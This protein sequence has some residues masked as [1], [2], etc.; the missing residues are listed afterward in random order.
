MTPLSR[1]TVRNLLN[2]VAG[3]PEAVRNDPWARSYTLALGVIK[4]FLGEDWI[5][6]HLKPESGAK[7]FLQ[8]DM[9]APEREVDF[10]RTVDLGEL[11]FNLQNVEGFD[12]CAARLKGGDIQGARR[13]GYR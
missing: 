12:G 2:T 3:F 9:D 7:G 1:L 4:H 8:P 10:F 5:E 11:L 13:I 6:Q